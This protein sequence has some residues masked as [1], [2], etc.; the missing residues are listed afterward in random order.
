MNHPHT[1]LNLVQVFLALDAR[2]FSA[3][4]LAKDRKTSK[5]GLRRTKKK[6][7]QLLNKELVGESYRILLICLNLFDMFQT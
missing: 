6:I 2:G 1:P 7:W 3:F 5:A 4:D